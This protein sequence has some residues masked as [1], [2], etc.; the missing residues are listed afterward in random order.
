MDLL[1]RFPASKHVLKLNERHV[2]KSRKERRVHHLR[3]G[4]T[5]A[6][7]GRELLPGNA[8]FSA[9]Q[10]SHYLASSALVHGLIHD[11]YRWFRTNAEAG[12]DDFQFSGPL[13]F[14]GQACFVL[15]SQQDI[16]ALA[17]HCAHKAAKRFGLPDVE[18]TTSDW[19]TL[20]EYD[21]PGNI[22]ELGAVI[23]RAALLG[24]GEQ[25]DIATALGLASPLGP[26][27]AEDEQVGGNSNVPEPVSSTF[28][29]LDQ[30]PKLHIERGLAITKGRVEGP[31]GA[32]VMLEINPLTR[33]ACAS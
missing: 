10:R 3:L 31:K 12:I 28:L 16:P 23:D 7:L 14:H 19:Q 9:A 27:L 2:L 30:I 5:I 29:T 25:L 13:P 4:R 18:P 11:C 26:D 22:R 21:W 15:P 24:N 17:V 6:V 32:A 8:I 1:G 33:R 20:I